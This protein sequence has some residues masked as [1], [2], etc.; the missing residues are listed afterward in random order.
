MIDAISFVTRLVADPRLAR[1]YGPLATPAPGVNWADH[2]RS[3]YITYNHAVGTCRMGPAG[4]RLAVVGPDLRVHGIQN[5][6]IA[7]ASVVPV[8]P[9]ATT[10]LLAVL[11]GEVAGREMATHEVAATR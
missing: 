8:I 3:T 7:D 10:N 1:F 9:H 4:D 2:V 11:I 6:W 5:L